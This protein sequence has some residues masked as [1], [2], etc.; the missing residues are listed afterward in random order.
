MAAVGTC[1]A[2][3]RPDTVPRCG[4]TDRMERRGAYRADRAAALS[5]VPRSTVHYWAREQILVPSVS[6]EKVK[7]WSYS[8]LMALRT[9][10]WLRATKTS[11]DGQVV[12][13]TTMR[14]VRRA[15]GALAEL[16]LDLWQDDATPSVG[17]DRSGQIVIA[18]DDAPVLP[19]GQEILD[20]D[21]LDLLRPFDLGRE[22]HGPDLVAPR[23]RLRIVPG[24]LAGAPHVRRTRIET[25]ALA[26]LARRGMQVAK[27]ARLYPAIETADVEQALDLELQLQEGLALVA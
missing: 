13:A 8:D 17:V 7:L 16:D 2:M 9:I 21:M 12:P 20:A 5:G 11:P 18:A 15:L 14:A 24:K 1:S 4:H 10:A 23:P 6:P 25:E 19:G 3:L 22:V 26:A 27:I